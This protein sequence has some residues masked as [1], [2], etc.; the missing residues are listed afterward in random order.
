[1][2]IFLLV[3]LMTF[4]SIASA[5]EEDNENKEI[6]LDRLNFIESKVNCRAKYQE[7]E[8]TN[9][10]ALQQYIECLDQLVQKSIHDDKLTKYS[11]QLM[12]TVS[13][14][15]ANDKTNDINT[16][17]LSK[18]KT[19]SKKNLKNITA[20]YAP[21]HIPYPGGHTL[22]DGRYYKVMIGEFKTENQAIIAHKVINDF[23]SKD[24]PK[25]YIVKT[26]FY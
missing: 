23:F 25:I 5:N 1:M 13:D 6:F 12:V 21:F 3:I 18:K 4:S 11:I 24:Y 17:L 8:H 15:K 14:A 10:N 22:N 20:W 19:L 16:F 7:Q 26:P 9:Q 2:K